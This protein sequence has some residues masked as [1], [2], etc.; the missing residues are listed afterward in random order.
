MGVC[1][2]LL[3]RASVLAHLCVMFSCVFFH[4]PIQCPG[5]VVVLDC[6]NS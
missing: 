5:L 1:D 4:F 3:G 6:I 2:H